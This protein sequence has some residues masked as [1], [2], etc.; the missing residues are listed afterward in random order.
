MANPIPFK[1]VIDP[2]HELNR[3][4]ANAPI[5]H[6]EA[7]LVCYDIIQTAHN[8]GLLDLLD[9]LI[10]GKDF[11]AGKLAEYAKLPGGVAAIRNLIAGAK[12]LMALDPDT[13]DNLSRSITA[14]TAQHQ[15]ETKAPSLWQLAKRATSEDSRRGLS[16]MTLLL[17]AVGKSL[18]T[19]PETHTK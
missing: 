18:A 13:L 19:T 4:L 9:G 1:V 14:A 10:S 7:L 15:A 16:F 6:A 3:Q 5:E 8:N 17:G 12:I 2:K 11:I